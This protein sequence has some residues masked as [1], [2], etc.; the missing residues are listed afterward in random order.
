M[1]FG[2]PGEIVPWFSGQLGHPYNPTA[3]SISDWVV[4]LVPPCCLPRAMP[5]WWQDSGCHALP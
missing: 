2:K 4:D 3:G 1:Y 5:L